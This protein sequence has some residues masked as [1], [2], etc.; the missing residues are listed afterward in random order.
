MRLFGDRFLVDDEDALDL[1]SGERVRLT[2]DEAPAREV[3]RDRE[4]A[5]TQR[6]QELWPDVDRLIH[7]SGMD[8]PTR[9]KK[10]TD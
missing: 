9:V 2:I 7:W 3:I 4:A 1:A 8:L 6:Q 5:I 10:L